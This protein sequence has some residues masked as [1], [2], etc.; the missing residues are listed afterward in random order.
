M[1]PIGEDVIW[2]IIGRNWVG[3]PPAISDIGEEIRDYV[4]NP[5]Y[6]L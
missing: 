4:V 5:F 2:G 1:K 3:L 6:V